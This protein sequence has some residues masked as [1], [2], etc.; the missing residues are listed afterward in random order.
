[1]Y[2]SITLKGRNVT[3]E[4]SDAWIEKLQSLRYDRIDRPIFHAR[5]TLDCRRGRVIGSL[6]YPG[7]GEDGFETEDRFVQGSFPFYRLVSVFLSNGYNLVHGSS[8]VNG[9]ERY[10]FVY[11]KNALPVMT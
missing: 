3:V 8:N 10:M 7:A 5:S 2:S 6:E 4:G 9:S 1:M 11:M